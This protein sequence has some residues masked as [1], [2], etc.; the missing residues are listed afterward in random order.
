M[1]LRVTQSPLEGAADRVPDASLVI[2]AVHLA[3]SPKRKKKVRVSQPCGETTDARTQALVACGNLA[4]RS[5]HPSAK[6]VRDTC[7]A[8]P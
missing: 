7:R 3:D 1:L 5:S 8:T 6:Q 4:V 2:H